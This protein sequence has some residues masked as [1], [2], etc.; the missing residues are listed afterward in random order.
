[1][2]SYPWLFEKTLDIG[3]T[4]SKIHAMRKMGVPYPR[5]Y[6]DRANRDLQQQAE[7]IAANLQREKIGI[8]SDKEI[9]A[10]IA[11]LQRVGKDIRTEEK[12]ANK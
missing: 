7:A 11:Y 4:K 8:K 3:S 1:M 6:E 2:P 9:I 12:N 5:N 10:L